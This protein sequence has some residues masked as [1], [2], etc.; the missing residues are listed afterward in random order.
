MKKVYSL[1]LAA[2]VSVSAYANVDLATTKATTMSKEMMTVSSEMVVSASDMQKAPQREA[3]APADVL[4]TYLYH[5]INRSSGDDGG[6]HHQVLTVLMNGAQDGDEHGE[7]CTLYGIFYSY[8]IRALFNETAGTIRVYEQPI[9]MNS[10]YNEMMTL[11]T[12]DA[13]TSAKIPYIEFEYV[14]DGVELTY[15]ATG[16]KVR[17]AE[18]GF[19]APLLNQFTVTIPSMQGTNNGWMWKYQNWF[20]TVEIEYAD[21]YLDIVADEWESV[22]NATLEDGWVRATC[23]EGQSLG[24]YSVPC[25][26]NKANDKLFLLENPYGTGTPYAQFNTLNVPGNIAFEIITEEVENNDGE[27]VPMTTVA[28]YPFILSGYDNDETVGSPV[29]CTNLEGKYHFMLGST[30]EDM[31]YDFADMDYPLSTVGADGKTLTLPNCRVQYS[32]I[33]AEVTEQWINGNEQPIPMESTITLPVSVAGVEGVISDVENAPKRFFNL[34][35]ME[36]V[37]PA[38]G[39]LVIVKQGNKT[40]KVIVK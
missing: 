2:A 25:K 10:Y 32:G 37:N 28:V 20:D 6:E 8:P 38:A 36:V 39:E 18:K 29:Y 5:A 30:I 26:R 34:Q 7:N 1:A 16:E 31:Y 15:S 19:F 22:G 13:E 27:L 24:S 12:E 35:G 33:F 17:V 21:S 4:D 14:P 11:Y 40:S 23:N 3:I 9:V